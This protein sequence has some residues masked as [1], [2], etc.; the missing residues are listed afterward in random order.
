MNND[1]T[2][3]TISGGG[4]GS[5]YGEAGQDIADFFPFLNE[6]PRTA[7]TYRSPILFI[8]R[9]VRRPMD[10]EGTDSRRRRSFESTGT[11]WMAETVD[12]RQL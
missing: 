3:S 12:W 7:K 10:R 5:G 9:R 1:R 4:N 2:V 6:T 8:G 11:D